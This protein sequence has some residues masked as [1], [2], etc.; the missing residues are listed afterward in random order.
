MHSH[1]WRQDCLIDG[2]CH[3]RIETVGDCNWG[4]TA[5][6]FAASSCAL[7]STKRH[8][9]RAVHWT[10]HSVAG[11]DLCTGQHT[12]LPP[13]S[14]ALDSAQRR[15]PRAVQ[16]TAHSVASLGLCNGQRTASPALGC[17]ILVISFAQ[18]SHM[19]A[20]RLWPAMNSTLLQQMFADI[21]IIIITFPRIS[22]LCVCVPNVRTQS[23]VCNWHFHRR[24]LCSTIV[25][26]PI[27]MCTI[28]ILLTL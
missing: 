23:W 1:L 28:A 26:Y 16:W 6:S 22:I 21:V 15:W 19:D 11:L 10:A 5:H 17:A 7:D 3:V 18:I 8:R 13:S 12:A 27:S 4:W 14:C 2:T 20:K 9:L 24:M 25:S